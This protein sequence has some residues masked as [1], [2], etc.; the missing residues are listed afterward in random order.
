MAF[1]IYSSGCN[2]ISGGT[3]KALV[4]GGFNTFSVSATV[5]AGTSYYI[6][7]S[8]DSANG[9]D[10]YGTNNFSGNYAA[11]MRT[12][13]PTYIFVGANTATWSTGAVTFPSTCGTKGANVGDPPGMFWY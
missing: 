2:L 3:G 11:M 13:D 7:L 5:T 12:A 9:S 6:A 4:S 1:A 8:S 10:A